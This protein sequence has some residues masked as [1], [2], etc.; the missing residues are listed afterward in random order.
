MLPGGEERDR[1][2]I[3]TKSAAHRAW[4]RHITLCMPTASVFL[5]RLQQVA[6]KGDP[7]YISRQSW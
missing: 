3:T 2:S 1:A 4:Y 6:K 7:L 5:V